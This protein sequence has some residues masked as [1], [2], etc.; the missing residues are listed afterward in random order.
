MTKACSYEWEDY[1][2]LA[3][4]INTDFTPFAARHPLSIATNLAARGNTSPTPPIYF[5]TPTPCSV[6]RIGKR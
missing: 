3:D 5:H 2:T 4:T 6:P 1:P